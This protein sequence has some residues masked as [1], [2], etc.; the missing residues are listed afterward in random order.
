M[1]NFRVFKTVKTKRIISGFLPKNLGVILLFLLLFPYLVAFLFGNLQEGNGAVMQISV[2]EQLTSGQYL[3]NNRSDMGLESIP[4][5][6]YVADK[7]ARTMEA[8]SEPEALKAQA[9]LIRSGIFWQ[10]NQNNENYRNGNGGYVTSER[11]SKTVEI[12]DELYGSVAVS[13]ELYRAVA[14]TAGLCIMYE[15]RPIVGAYFA[16]S[17]GAT[18][19]GEGMGLYEYPYLKGVL[20]ERDFLS[21][22]YSSSLELREDEF[23]K[24]WEGIPEAEEKE[25]AVI[26]A[27]GHEETEKDNNEDQEDITYVR[28]SAGYVLFLE[29][30]NKTVSGESFRQAYG[31]L[32]SCFYLDRESGK[33]IISVKG[34]GHGLGMS[35][36]GAR[37]LAA[38][39]KTC[40]EIL[41]YFFRD[42]TISKIE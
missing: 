12:T 20:C 35:L 15:N 2:E 22:E 37:Q 26:S 29:Y 38:E 40:V 8:D 6:I 7:L 41:E 14:E 31:L 36:Y 18:R 11:D 25:G 9:I 1:K 32:S 39:G 28:D 16:V 5:E 33:V 34:K 3:V 21:E 23:R 30:D 27:S 13:E 17:N 4:L 24:I 42:V 10:M 19:N